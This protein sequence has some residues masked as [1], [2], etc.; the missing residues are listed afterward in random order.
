MKSKTMY[1][2]NMHDSTRFGTS[3]APHAPKTDA[4]AS[5]GSMYR[6]IMSWLRLALSADSDDRRWRRYRSPLPKPP[7]P[8]RMLISPPLPM[9]APMGATDDHHPSWSPARGRPARPVHPARQRPP[10]TPPLRFNSA[11][12]RHRGARPTARPRRARAEA[13]RTRPGAALRVRLSSHSRRWRRPPALARRVWPRA[14][15]PTR[16]HSAAAAATRPARAQHLLEH[17]KLPRRRL[18]R[19]SQIEYIDVKMSVSRPTPHPFRRRADR[20]SRARNLAGAP[21]IRPAFR[22]STIL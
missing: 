13:R 20:V 3:S 9:F 7:A 18:H 8:R 11:R 1:A 6:F 21:P 19:A 16:P 4:V 5:H 12:A 22:N 17:F 10:P 15:L 2:R 14:A